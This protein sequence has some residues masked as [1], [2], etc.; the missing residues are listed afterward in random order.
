MSRRLMRRVGDSLRKTTHEG[1]LIILPWAM[2]FLTP[3]SR[4]AVP[5]LTGTSL[6]SG[7]MPVVSSE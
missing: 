5:S 3:G 1:K 7:A 6:P 2:F 4:G